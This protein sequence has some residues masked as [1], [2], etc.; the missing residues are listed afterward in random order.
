M[1]VSP[2]VADGVGDAGSHD[3]YVYA[4]D[5]ESGELLR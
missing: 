1:I 4:L 3:S 2:T 5:S